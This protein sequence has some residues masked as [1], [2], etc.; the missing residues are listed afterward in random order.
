[1]DFLRDKVS[2]ASSVWEGGREMGQ[3]EGSDMGKGRQPIEGMPLVQKHSRGLG[4]NS[5]GRLKYV[6]CK[7]QN[8]PHLESR[9][10]MRTDIPEMY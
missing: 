5:L 10:L 7:P 8:Y 1:M 6:A 2:N 9:C 4:H 3:Q